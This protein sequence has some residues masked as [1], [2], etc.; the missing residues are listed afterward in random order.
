MSG[1]AIAA[2]IGVTMFTQYEESRGVKTGTGMIH[3]VRPREAA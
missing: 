2:G 1:R 3:R